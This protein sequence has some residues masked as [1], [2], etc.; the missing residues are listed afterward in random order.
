MSTS[1]PAVPS[2][3]FT[4][5]ELLAAT[6][7]ELA[8]LG[9]GVAV[10][11]VRTDSRALASGELFVA[12]RG[13]RHDGHEHLPEAVARGAAALVVERGTPLDGIACTTIVV[14]ETLAALGDLAAHHRRRHPIPLIAVGGSNGKTTTKSMVAAILE[15]AYGAA[16]VVATRGSRNNLVGMPETLLGLDATTRVAVLE[17]GMNA[18]GEMW[19]LA[20]IAQPDVGLVTC[21]AE[22]HL[23]GVGSLR[24]AAEANGELYRRLR[25]SGTAVVN[26]DDPLVR[27]I[28]RAF[29][30]RHVSFG[31]TGDVRAHDVV[32]EGVYGTSFVL[33]ARGERRPLRL[34]IAGRHNV[35]NALAA[36]AAALAVA[37]PTDAICAALEGIQAPSMRMEVL[38]VGDGIT[39]LNDCYNANPGSMAAALQTL[40]ASAAPRRFAALGEM[41][42]L[43]ASAESAHEEVG[44]RAADARVDG[45]FL[46]GTHAARVRDAAVAAGLPSDRIGIFPTHDA[47]AEAL[48]AMLRAGDLLL[49]KGSRGAALERVVQQLGLERPR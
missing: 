22:E 43:G 6:G 26:A 13:E 34:R 29:A 39:V 11:G 30:G 40:A 14:R 24:G 31:D 41:L 1:P 19:R 10:R 44:R 47:M 16:H 45:L 28:A 48:R 27:D 18:P 15:H 4:L 3:P 12:L 17:M 32:D 42:E 23:A 8:R 46:M 35:S 7:G 36:T 33:D 21:I 2:T 25:P 37:V 9:A 49:V 5:A 38:T 20:E